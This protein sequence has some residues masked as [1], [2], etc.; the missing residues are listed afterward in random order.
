LA[1]HRRRSARAAR[2]SC[3]GGCHGGSARMKA[4]DAS[5]VRSVRAAAQSLVGSAADYDPLLDLIGRARF[6]LLGEASHGTHDFYDQRAQQVLG[7]LVELQR[8][9]A[10][11][12]SRDGRVAEDE[13]FFAEQNARLVKNAEQ[14]YRSMFRG[15]VESW[16]KRDAHMAETLE[17]LVAHLTSR[18]QTA[19]IAVW[20]HNSHLGDARA[21]EIGES[22]E[23]NVG[24]L[25]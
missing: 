13:F 12:A 8:H 11:Y 10:D 14:Y 23:F 5:L 24:Q 9:A 7:E 22:G 16:N 2:G 1:D 6:V 17:A 19:K 25:V 21:T 4:D 20:E 15:R 18:G 3:A